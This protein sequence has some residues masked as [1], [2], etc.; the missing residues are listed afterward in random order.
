MPENHSP[1]NAVHSLVKVSIVAIVIVVAVVLALIITSGFK[2]VSAPKVAVSSQSSSSTFQPSASPSVTQPSAPYSTG[3]VSGTVAAINT[4]ADSDRSHVTIVL[5]NSAQTYVCD[6][7][8]ATDVRIGDSVKLDCTQTLKTSVPF[9]DLLT[10]SR[11]Q[12]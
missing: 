9:C 11:E 8:C 1:R 12:P 3:S 7:T 4:T 10:L 5:A 6:M 2:V